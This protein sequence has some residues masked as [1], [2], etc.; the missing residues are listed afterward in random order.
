MNAEQPSA[1]VQTF[2]ELGSLHHAEPLQCNQTLNAG[3]DS[4]ISAAMQ[5]LNLSSGDHSSDVQHT[6]SQTQSIHRRSNPPRRR[7][8]P[9]RYRAESYGVIKALSTSNDASAPRSSTSIR[10]GGQLVSRQPSIQISTA[11]NRERL[12][13]AQ[14]RIKQ[15]ERPVKRY[16]KLLRLQGASLEE[17]RAFLMNQHGGI[18]AENMTHR[19]D[20]H[21]EQLE[22]QVDEYCN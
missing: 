18:K 13:A 6:P 10:V 14:E 21:V 11:D 16:K 3:E 12:A 9:Q 1:V 2:S 22:G 8:L 20:R 19:V 5:N 4:A 15:L 7:H 17:M